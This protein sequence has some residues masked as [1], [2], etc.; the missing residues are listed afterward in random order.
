MG[1]KL[2]YRILASF[3]PNTASTHEADGIEGAAAGGGGGGGEFDKCAVSPTESTSALTTSSPGTATS[4]LASNELA[5]QQ[6]Q[7]LQQ[8]QLSSKTHNQ[9]PPQE[10]EGVPM[11][12]DIDV[13][14]PIPETSRTAALQCA[15]ILNRPYREVFNDCKKYCINK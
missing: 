10:V 2:A 14:M 1:E 3:A 7:P 9:Q 15:Q 13:V 11:L 12:M 5:L 4:A 8:Q 6:Q